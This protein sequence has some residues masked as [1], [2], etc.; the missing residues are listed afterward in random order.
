MTGRGLSVPA[1]R[2]GDAACFQQSSP[3]V[4]GLQRR[5]AVHRRCIRMGNDQTAVLAVPAW[6]RSAVIVL[7]LMIK[8]AK[9]KD[10]P[11]I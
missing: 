6:A 5:R 1:A 7:G 11:P 9:L 3:G 2:C 4:R 8:S 10:R